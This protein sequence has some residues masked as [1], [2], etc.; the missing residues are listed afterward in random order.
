MT[1]YKRPDPHK[2][3]HGDKIV[4]SPLGC[5]YGGVGRIE[6]RGRWTQREIGGWGATDLIPPF[7]SLLSH[8]PL[9]QM[10]DGRGKGMHGGTL[11]FPQ[12][13]PLFFT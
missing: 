13:T 7:F 10:D 9:P 1:L 11:V 8:T 6:V 5:P 3:T 4:L 2:E 12:S